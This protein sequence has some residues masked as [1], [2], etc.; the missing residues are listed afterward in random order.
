[1]MA[2]HELFRFSSLLTYKER[3]LVLGLAVRYK[4][5]LGLAIRQKFPQLVLYSVCL[6]S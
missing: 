2:R 1:M 3:F 5:F 4:S 6:F